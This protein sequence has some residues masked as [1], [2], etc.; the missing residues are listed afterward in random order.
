M[1]QIASSTAPAGKNHGGTSL[2]AVRNAQPLHI[3]LLLLLL[4]PA[5]CLLLL[6]LQQG[7]TQLH[8]TR[9]A[10]RLL[11]VSHD[12]HPCQPCPPDGVSS[13]SSDAEAG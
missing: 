10:Q 5:I 7:P 11:R 9:P 12:L 4:L 8:G 1:K 3:C 6:L 13:D 2:S